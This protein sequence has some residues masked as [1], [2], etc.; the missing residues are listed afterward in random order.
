MRRL[1]RIVMY[2][3]EA[4]TN[5]ML[6]TAG[7]DAGDDPGFAHP[8]LEIRGDE[9]IPDLLAHYASFE[10]PWKYE[11]VT[12]IVADAAARG[13]KVLLWTNFVR[14]IRLLTRELASY[15]PAVV[16]G[17]V[18]S[19]ESASPGDLTRD[20]E[21]ARFRHDPS[22]SVL[23][24]NPAA[25]GEGVSLHHWCHHAVYL[26]RS[27]NAG[28]FLQSQDRIHRLGL[29][30]DV[31]TRFTLLISAGTIDDTVD[32]RLVDKVVALSTLMND[33]GLVQIAL[34]APDE[35]EG[36]LPAFDDD[37]LA[38]ANHLGVQHARAA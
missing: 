27:F 18:P 1:R 17:G 37:V 19:A 8:P 31:L 4:A 36:G 11:E 6:L 20:A 13:E 3:L 5:P 10:T 21:F 34:P 33:P 29:G 24:A 30:D 35:G 22:C 23:L 7:S 15:A 26:D 32:G 12:R 14:N 25:C 28:H 2:L 38:V 16:H 9:S